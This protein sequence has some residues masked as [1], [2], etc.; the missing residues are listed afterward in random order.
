MRNPAPD[1]GPDDIYGIWRINDADNS[2]STQPFRI[3]YVRQDILLSVMVSF[4]LSLSK[5]E[6]RFTLIIF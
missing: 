5:F 2:F 4:N 3:K 1:L 6:V